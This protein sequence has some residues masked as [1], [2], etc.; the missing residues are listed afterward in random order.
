VSARSAVLPPPERRGARIR[1]PA[2]IGVDVRRF[3][4]LT[5]TIA[6]TE[7]KL[8]FY[9]SALGY[10]WQLV[11]PLLLFGVLYLFFTSFVDFP[12]VKYYGVVLLM[13][14]MLF[15]FLADATQVAVS[16]LVDREVLVRKIQFPRLA[17]PLA[18][19]LTAGFNLGLNFLIVLAFLIAHG[20]TPQWTWLELPLLLAIL[21]FF[22]V[23]ICMLLSAMYVRFRDVKP[24]WDVLLQALYFVS[25]VLIPYE[26]VEQ[27][28][29]GLA[30][31][32]M[33]N[34]FAAIIQE[35]RHAVIDPSAKSAA[36]AAGGWE[37]LLIPGGIVLALA[38]IGFRV[39]DREAPYVADEL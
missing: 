34:P 21:A 28:S 39:F 17:L 18:A 16:S 26:A 38:V 6:A 37:M 8:R 30:E 14:I 11:R 4:N 33:L 10:L 31:A 36:A 1:G 12:A 32:V 29:P 35:M 5:R 15:T 3:V 27:E 2:A 9:G 24:I 13:G 19:V 20:G 25:L 7:F 22:V 23:G